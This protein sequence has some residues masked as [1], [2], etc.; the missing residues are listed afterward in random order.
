MLQGAKKFFIKK[1]V[2]DAPDE[3]KEYYQYNP[4]WYPVC[5]PHFFL[6]P[7]TQPQPQFDNSTVIWAIRQFLESKGLSG[8]EAMG[9]RN[10]E[11]PCWLNP[12]SSYFFIS[13]N[14][15]LYVTADGAGF[16]GFQFSIEIPKCDDPAEGFAVVDELMH[17]L[18]SNK[19]F[20]ARAGFLRLLA[21]TAG[22]KDRSA[23]PLYLFDD[24]VAKELCTYLG[25]TNIA[26]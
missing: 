22:F 8:K 20:L 13:D 12:V 4:T 16:N 18:E 15:Y 5:R 11:T 21:G 3:V 6:P 2:G 19:L 17:Y 14:F 7:K 24:N 23:I 10:D 1:R 26:F 25:I 9:V